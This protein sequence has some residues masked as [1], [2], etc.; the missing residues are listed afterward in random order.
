MFAPGLEGL[1]A[2]G[3][4]P[5]GVAA[6]VA[7]G[8]GGL[9]WL[10]LAGVDAGVG[11]EVA[12]LAIGLSTT[13]L[14]GV[15]TGVGAGVNGANA[16]GGPPASTICKSTCS[17]ISWILK[18]HMRVDKGRPGTVAQYCAS[19]LNACHMHRKHMPQERSC[20]R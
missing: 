19:P 6:E 14:A 18:R 11:E 10:L 13:L 16:I 1:C 15:D 4:E 2:A 7:T 5:C 12:W 3:G 8:L 9:P 20:R 17:R